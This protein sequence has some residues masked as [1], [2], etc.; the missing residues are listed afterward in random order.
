MA[1]FKP[2]C[3]VNSVL[4]ISPAMLKKNHIKAVLIDIDDTL[5]AHGSPIIEKEISDWINLMTASGI[6]LILVSNNFK[7][8]VQKFAKK[9]SLSFVY[10]SCKPLPIG[11][12]GALR[13]AKVKKNE[14][15]IVGDQIFTDILGANLFGMKSILVEPRSKSKTLSLKLKRLL[16]KPIRNR[17]TKTHFY[18]SEEL[19]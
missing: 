8:R 10:L 9:I 15:M 1:I 3:F 17:L 16:E 5:T 12:F 18:H 19:K 11:F 13:K 14:A 4:E 2:G 7:K 6:R